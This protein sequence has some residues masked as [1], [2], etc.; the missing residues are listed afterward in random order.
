LRG[1]N[2]SGAAK[3]A[4]YFGYQQAADFQRIRDAWGMNAVRFLVL[5]AALEP[6]PGNYDDAYIDGVAQRIAWAEAANLLVVVDMHQDVY[7]EGFASGGG[8]GAP[9]WTCDEAAYAS[10][11]PVTPWFFNNLSKEVT[12]CYDHFWQTDDLHKHYAEGWR[13]IAARLASSKVVL[14]FDPMNE[15]Y[16]G[17]APIPHFEPE[18]LGPFYEEVVPV[19]RSAA[20]N[21]IAFIEP[22]SSRNLGGS[23]ALPAP[24]YANV[25]YSPHSYDRDAESGNGFDSAHR[26]ALVM[27]VAALANEAHGMNAALWIGEYGGNNDAPGIVDYMTAQYDAAGAVAA[28][29]MYWDYSRGGGYSLVADDDSEKMPLVDILARP[30]PERVAGDP[31]AWTYDAA[32]STFTFT[33]KPNASIMAPTILSIPARRYPKGYVVECGGCA[34]AQ[35]PGALTITS[36]PSA[37]PAVVTIHP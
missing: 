36:P 7:G 28:S 35:S 26:D 25:A 27:N 19:V 33:Y 12:G 34:S 17:S 14:G 15:P 30:Y 8:D 13:R 1:L 20:P 6:S 3:A 29:S 2:V 23:T 5:W 16:W 4:P 32:T 21:W 22:S 18:I 31:I 9:R 24:S 11:M 37:S 10:F